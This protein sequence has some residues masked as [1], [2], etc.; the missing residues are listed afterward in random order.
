MHRLASWL[1]AAAVAC[2]AAVA[3]ADD[4]TVETLEEAPPAEVASAIAEKL[5]KTGIKVRSS[6]T[7]TVCDL[8]F[9]DAA[10]AKPGFES[11]A[12]ALYPFEMGQ[13]LG[14]IRFK[15]KASDFRGQELESGTYI[16]RFALQPE[17]GNHVGTSDTRDFLVLSKPDEDTDPA[18]VVQDML[19]MRSAAAAGG[20]H[21]AMLS[22]THPPE[23]PATLGSV[24]HDEDRDWYILRFALAVSDGGKTAQRPVSLI[25]RG[26]AVE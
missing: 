25:V 1:V 22:L 12:S 9:V 20:T 10:A 18:V 15:R 26:H 6:P 16:L 7:S 19:F 13:L 14:V 3:Q 8:W 11:S 23:S 4:F 24:E 2:S 17:D 5:T 21:P